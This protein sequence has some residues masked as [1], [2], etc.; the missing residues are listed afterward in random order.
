MSRFDPVWPEPTGPTAI[1]VALPE[2]AE[3][4]DRWRSVSYSADRPDLPLSERVPPH[5]T[6]LVPWVTDPSPDDVQRLTDAVADVIPFEVSFSSAGRF[7]DGTAWLLPEP[8]D[9]I[10]ALTNAV[11][12]AF[13][14]CPPYGGKHL[15]PHPHLTICAAGQGG[16]KVVAEA[17]EALAVEPPPAVLLD[18]L[19]IWREGEDRVWQLI[20][21]VPLGSGA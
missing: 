2:L 20:G 9:E 12:F 10:L 4:T 7:E 17:E 1:L 14:E 8:Y 18:D 5:V 13:P 3:F 11:L 16:P 21:S 19:T 6:V 15:D